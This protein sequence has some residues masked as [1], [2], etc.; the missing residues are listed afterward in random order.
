MSCMEMRGARERGEAD[1]VT[2]EDDH[3]GM[4]LCNELLSVL[5]GGHEANVSEVEALAR[6]STLKM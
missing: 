1:D 6:K 5:Q 3:V 2:E 4:G